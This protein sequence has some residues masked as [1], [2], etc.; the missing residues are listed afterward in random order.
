MDYF[1]KWVEILAIPDQTA[2]TCATKIL[3]EFIGRFGCPLSLYIVTKANILGV[4][5]LTNSIY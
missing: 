2:I 5:F 3:N 1:T 4:K